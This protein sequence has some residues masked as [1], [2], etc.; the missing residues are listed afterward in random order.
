MGT[1]S[2]YIAPDGKLYTYMEFVNWKGYRPVEGSCAKNA[3]RGRRTEGEITDYYDEEIGFRRF[4]ANFII[5][6]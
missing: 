2:T 5:E 1:P 3:R 4:E 6:D